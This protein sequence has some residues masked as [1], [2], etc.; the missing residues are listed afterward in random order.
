MLTKAQK[1]L[2][3]SAKKNIREAVKQISIL[4]KEYYVCDSLVPDNCIGYDCE[5]GVKNENPNYKK[6]LLSNYMH[7]IGYWEGTKQ[8]SK[9]IISFIK[10]EKSDFEKFLIKNAEI[11]E[12]NKKTMDDLK[13]KLNKNLKI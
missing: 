4:Y 7:Q 6:D 9:K 13:K 8:M 3:K 5:D 10:M 11:K 1:Y 12:L 2:K